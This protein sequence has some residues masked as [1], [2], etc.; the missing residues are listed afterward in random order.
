ML[1]LQSKI[2]K[3]IYRLFCSLGTVCYTVS[4][5]IITLIFTSQDCLNDT[6]WAFVRHFSRTRKTAKEN[7]LEINKNTINKNKLNPF[8]PGVR[9]DDRCQ[10]M[11]MS[12]PG[13]KIQTGSV[14]TSYDWVLLILAC[15]P[16]I[17]NQV[18][19]GDTVMWKLSPPTFRYYCCT[20]IKLRLCNTLW[21]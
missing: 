20:L 21:T 3:R 7:Y 12:T 15:R 17:R 16:Y 8:R 13:L 19:K 11:F 14:V 9:S 1:Y 10:S 6:N 18:W 5:I 2:S 4:R